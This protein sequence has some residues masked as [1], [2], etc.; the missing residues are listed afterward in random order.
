MA[1]CLPYTDQKNRSFK[2]YQH[3]EYKHIANAPYVL[4]KYNDII[5]LYEINKAKHHSLKKEDNEMTINKSNDAWLFISA[6][7]IQPHN[8][9]DIDV[10]LYSQIEHLLWFIFN[11]AHYYN[12]M[13]YSI[14]DTKSVSYIYIYI[15]IYTYL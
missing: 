6:I 12:I 13:G 11:H 2:D 1:R 14:Q 8:W 10:V 9:A 7:N 3:G 4:T 5:H 15:Y